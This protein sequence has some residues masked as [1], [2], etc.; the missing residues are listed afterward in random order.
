MT[1]KSTPTRV[2]ADPSKWSEKSQRSVAADFTKDYTDIVY[3]CWRCKEPA[4]FSAADQKHTFEV[5][6]ASIDQRRTLCGDCW[7]ELLRIER[8]L[9]ICEEQ[10]SQSKKSLKLDT[11]FLSGWLD[12]VIEREQYVPYRPDTAKKNMLRKLLDEGS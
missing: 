2:P 7:K 3:D 8:N 1:A 9:R 11:S 5:K 10:W 6:K 12:L 4:V